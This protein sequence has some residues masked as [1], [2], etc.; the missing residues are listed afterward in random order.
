[1]RTVP[2]LRAA[3]GGSVSADLS[4]FGGFRIGESLFQ[5]PPTCTQNVRLVLGNQCFNLR[6]LIFFVRL[7]LGNHCF[8]LPQHALR[9]SVSYWGI[10]V[11]TSPDMH[12][13]CPSR[14]GESL[15]QPPQIDFIIGEIRV[16]WLAAG[17]LQ[18]V[19]RAILLKIFSKM[20]H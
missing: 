11:S 3:G 1:M 9:M 5:P 20:A 14:I 6:R 10:T 15:F 8:N 16:S 7:V 4:I 17:S 13:E 12:P 2:W 18:Y 19:W